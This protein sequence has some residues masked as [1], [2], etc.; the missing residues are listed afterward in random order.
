MTDIRTLVQ[1]NTAILEQIAQGTLTLRR[2]HPKIKTAASIF[3]ATADDAGSLDSS[4]SIATAY[5]RALATSRGP[6]NSELLNPPR[7][8]LGVSFDGNSPSEMSKSEM[9]NELVTRTLRDE[10]RSLKDQLRESQEA[11]QG[12]RTEKH[13]TESRLQAKVEQEAADGEKRLN[14]TIAALTVQSDTRL[15]ETTM[16][17]QMDLDIAKRRK[18]ELESQ[19]EHQKED[20]R[21]IHSKLTSQLQDSASR[22]KSLQVKVDKL[23]KTS[24]EADYQEL[25]VMMDNKAAEC[26]KLLVAVDQS[27]AEIEV[28]ESGYG[29]LSLRVEALEKLDSKNKRML[30]GGQKGLSNLRQTSIPSVFNL[31]SSET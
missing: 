2:T 30:K 1:S 20:F 9:Y 15:T 11:I 5:R 3:E 17:L 23:M 28:L 18:L 6:L 14:A 29:I 8:N 21:V 25:K 24:R 10:N 13:D 19:V 12:L 22:A 4:H 31:C 7:V 27:K 16:R 26:E